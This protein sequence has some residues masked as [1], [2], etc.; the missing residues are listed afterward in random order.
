MKFKFETQPCSRCGGT[1]NFSFNQ[2]TGTTC[3]KCNGSGKQAT[4]AGASAN[5]KVNA[6]LDALWNTPIEDLK[7]GD[8]VWI[9]VSGVFL[10]RLMRWA[11]IARI[12]PSGSYCTHTENGVE[13][14]TPYLNVIV[15]YKGKET[16]E[17]HLPGM[18]I[19]RWKAIPEETL[20]KIRKL[21]GVIV[22]EDKIESESV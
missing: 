6:M 20:A 2:V 22:E 7:P 11:K 5:K 4:R 13:V 18:T 21:K 8:L 19:R 9:N 15:A 1:G 3:F 17:G 10:G 12:E 16:G 14:K